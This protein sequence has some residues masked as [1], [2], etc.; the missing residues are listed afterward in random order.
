MADLRLIQTL[1]ALSINAGPYTK[2]TEPGYVIV[3]GVGLLGADVAHV[4]GLSAKFT[5]LSDSVLLVKAL[6]DD[7]I[8]VFTK[9]YTESGESLIRIDAGLRPALVTDG[10]SVLQQR[11]IKALLSDNGADAFTNIGGGLEQATGSNLSDS[12]VTDT[13][14]R[15]REVEEQLI[16]TQRADEPD[17]SALDSIN[18]LGASSD[19]ATG[20]RIQI[21]IINRAGQR[22]ETEV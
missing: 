7:L 10:P 5:T 19:G 13:I 12:A 4:N 15:I 3:R 17:E 20:A 9:T 2:S 11:V 18:I 6:E 14:A 8:E 1:R 21:E 16:T 22:I